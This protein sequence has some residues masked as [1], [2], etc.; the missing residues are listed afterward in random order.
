MSDIDHILRR[1]ESFLDVQKELYGPLLFDASEVPIWTDA[2]QTKE[3]QP[4]AAPAGESEPVAETD[5][6]PPQHTPTETNRTA[7]PASGTDPE[8]L[9]DIDS[10]EKLRELCESAEVL[11]TDLS[12]TNLVF[13][14]G[15]PQADLMIIGEAPGAEEDKLGEPFV[16]RSGQ[17]LT[18]ILKAIQF[19]REDVY[20]ANILKHRPPDNRDP[21]PDERARSLPYLLKQIE[22]INPKLILCLGRISAQT[23]MDVKSTMKEM[24]GTFHKFQDKYELMVT[25]HP[26]AL[27]RNPNWKR[28]TWEDVKLLRKRYDE[29]KGKP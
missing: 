8:F 17:L 27:L 24:R 11:R 26:A 18:Q 14:K 20:I 2:P 21:S 16:G 4:V 10:L 25:F 1:V 6:H 19:E 7:M 29:L 28:D 15:N 13:G 9:S 3:T 5:I 23:L 12:G 22:L